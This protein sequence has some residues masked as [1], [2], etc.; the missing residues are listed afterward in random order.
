MD[1]TGGDARTDRDATTDGD[2]AAESGS[3]PAGELVEHVDRHDRVV[4]IVTRARM[5]SENLRHRS[6]A[7]LITTSDRRLVVHRRAETKDLHPGWWDVAAGGVVAAGESY[8]AAASRELAEEAGLADV[9]LTPIGVARH[10]DEHSRE[11]CHAYTVVHDGPYEAV[12]GEVAEFCAVTA[13]ELDELMRRERFVPSAR[14][15]L[16]LVPGFGAGS[17]PRP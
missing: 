10:E 14:T 5:R 4:E 15:I 17:P 2:A 16:T 7:I 11:I 3:G 12:D 1:G 8:D 9:T 6:T 13:D